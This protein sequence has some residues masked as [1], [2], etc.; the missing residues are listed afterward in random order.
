MPDDLKKRIEALLFIISKGLSI[1]ELCE[2]TGCPKNQVLDAL[3]ELKKEYE[4]GNKAFTILNLNSVYRMTVH[5]ELING[6]E[7][8]VP[9]D[10]SKSLIKT[11]SVIAW[12]QG[13]TQGEVV[14]IRGNKAYEH[15][16][17]LNDM[18]F[19]ASEPYGKSC[20]LT[21]AEKFFEYFNI[22]KGEEKFIFEQFKIN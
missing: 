11:L 22:S 20:R 10:L 13:I 15:V 18:G 21:L 19:V 1:Q 17:A 4:T 7:D 8:L 6:V 12:K 16:K 9:A 5:R 3:N 2:K 14:R